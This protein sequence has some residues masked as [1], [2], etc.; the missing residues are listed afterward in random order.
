[1]RGRD[2]LVTIQ[3][4]A[5]GARNELNEPSGEW[6][7]HCRIWAARRDAGDVEQLAGDA[8]GSA[9]TAQ[10][11]VRDN[12]K[13]RAILPA[14]R[15]WDGARAWNIKG[16]LQRAHNGRRDLVTLVAVADSTDGSA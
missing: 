1:M 9:L 6:V 10:F 5:D 13:T 3:K 15:I 4:Y 8:T 12:E 16:V 7:T 2:Q 14:M 11:V